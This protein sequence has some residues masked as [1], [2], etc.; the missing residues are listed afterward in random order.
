MKKELR[1]GF[2]LKMIFV[3]QYSNLS[4]KDQRLGISHG[5]L[6]LQWSDFHELGEF[7]PLIILLI[8]RFVD[9]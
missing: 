1:K 9:N 4:L 8:L 6:M 7:V 2:W 3:Y 5:Q